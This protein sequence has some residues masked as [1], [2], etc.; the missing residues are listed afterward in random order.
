MRD[1]RLWLRRVSPATGAMFAAAIAILV[2]FSVTALDGTFQELAAR[3][4][5]RSRDIVYL[6][7]AL[8]GGWGGGWFIVLFVDAE[9]LS[10]MTPV[11]YRSWCVTAGSALIAAGVGAGTLLVWLF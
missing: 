3:N 5:K 7:A 6:L 10:V 9:S 2:V 4:F 1:A 11:D 8:F